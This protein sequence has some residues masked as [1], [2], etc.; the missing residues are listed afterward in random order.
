MKIFTAILLFVLLTTFDGGAQLY[1]QS[2]SEETI[3]ALTSDSANTMINRVEKSEEEWKEILDNKEFKILR[4]KGTELPYT[5]EYYNNK[6]EG[7]YNCAGCGT[8]LFTSKTKYKSGTGWPSFYA[9]KQKEFIALK[10]DNSLFM[11]RTEVLCAVC[12][13]HLGHVFDDGPEPTGLRYCLNSAAFDFEKKNLSD[14][15]DNDS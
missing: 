8:E 5:N 2:I 1:D 3:K 11:K 15:S 6:E 9:P 10:E 12:D 4:K 14:N 13:G 7:V